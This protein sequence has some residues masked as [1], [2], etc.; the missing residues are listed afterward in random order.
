M[1]CLTG[2]LA[3]CLKLGGLDPTDVQTKVVTERCVISGFG[4]DSFRKTEIY[5][6][7]KVV[8]YVS[9]TQTNVK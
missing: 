7:T 2:P 1:P 8:T 3:C 4:N 6:N 5:G 9:G